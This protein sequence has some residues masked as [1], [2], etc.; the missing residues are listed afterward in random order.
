GLTKEKADVDLWLKE[1]APSTELR[2]WFGH[3]PERFAEF[4]RRYREELS[5]HPEVLTQLSALESE[6]GLITLVYGAHDEEHNQ[7]V[8]LADALLGRRTV[9]SAVA[10]RAHERDPR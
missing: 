6:H 7:A 3:Q 9:Q 1:A 5:Q 2:A 10:A 4:S 8:V